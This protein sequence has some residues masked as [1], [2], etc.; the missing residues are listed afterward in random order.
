MTLPR[1]SSTACEVKFSD[2]MRL[3]KC[4]CRFFS[5]SKAQHAPQQAARVSQAEFQTDSFDDVKHGRV[6]L[7]QMRRKKLSGS[8]S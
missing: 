2:G 1:A 5:C 3:M 6:G 8:S 4:F 7:C